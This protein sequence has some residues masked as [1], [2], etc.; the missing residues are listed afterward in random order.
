[1]LLIGQLM[2]IFTPGMEEK[3]NTY[4][5]YKR[6]KEQSTSG[7]HYHQIIFFI[8]CSETNTDQ[9]NCLF[10]FIQSST[11]NTVF[12]NIFINARDNSV[13]S[14]GSLIAI[15]N[16]DPI[17]DY[18]NGVPIIVSNEQS[19]LM[20]PMNHSPIPMRNDLEANQSEGFVI[21]HSII[22]FG[23]ILFLDTKYSGKFCDHQNVRLNNN[24]LCRCFSLKSS[25]SNIISMHSICFYSDTGGTKMMRKFSSLKFLV[26]FK[27][28]NISVDI[29]ASRL[30]SGNV[31]A[32]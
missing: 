10:C 3:S 32:V 24:K 17:E 16:P 27:K 29:R 28:G 31:N 1:M 19:I 18:M 14:I 21:Q 8:F 7:G 25:C 9:A 20:L 15:V 2:W 6:A 4:T 22:Q 5:Y 12:F 13:F 30:Q 26:I 11:S 23:R